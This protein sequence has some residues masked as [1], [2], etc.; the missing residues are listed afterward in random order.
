MATLEADVAGKS[1]STALD[2]WKTR[3]V[4]AFGS[5]FVIINP[6]N[7]IWYFV[8]VGIM[9]SFVGFAN[10]MLFAYAI[11]LY[12][13]S[14]WVLAFLFLTLFKSVAKYI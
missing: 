3:L 2:N 11:P 12:F 10:G 1:A 6:I 14:W 9:F 8:C 4:L 7:I 13:L 5:S